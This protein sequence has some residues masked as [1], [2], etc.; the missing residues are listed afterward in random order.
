[1]TGG[2]EGEGGAPAGNPNRPPDD[3]RE[4]RDAFADNTVFD[5]SQYAFFGMAVMDEVELGGLKDND[6]DHDGFIG[7]KDEYH[8]SPPGDREDLFPS[9]IQD[10][11]E[12]EG[13]GSLSGIDDLASTFAKLNRVVND[14]KGAG[15][16]GDRGSFSRESE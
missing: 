2:F 1:M 14:P 4:L 11:Y 16:I 15:V 13:L 10:V 3:P 8:F 12:P 7:I 9:G 5:A 6:N